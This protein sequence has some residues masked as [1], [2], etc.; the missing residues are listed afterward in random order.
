MMQH[1]DIE[2]W[3]VIRFNSYIRISAS[4]LFS[5]QMILYMAIVVYAPSIALIQVSD[6]E[7]SY[8]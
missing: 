5:V 8:H 3:Y 4:I 7:I 1:H 6:I 2:S